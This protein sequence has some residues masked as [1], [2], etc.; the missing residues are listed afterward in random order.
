M[1]G[2]G[3]TGSAALTDST[4]LA[5]ST[6]PADSAAL[7][8]SAARADRTARATE[9]AAPSMYAMM[10]DTRSDLIDAVAQ[11]DRMIAQLTGMR[12]EAI[13]QARQWS[14]VAEDGV[15]PE[16]ARRSL[17]AEIACALRMPER[18][19][20]AMIEDSRALATDF[21]ATLEALRAG[22]IGYRHAQ[23]I[24]D[25]G[26]RL[27]PETRDA[28]E[29]AALPI[30]ATTTPSALDRRVRALRDRLDPSAM[31]ERHRRAAAD[32]SVDCAGARDGI[33]WLTAYLPV[34]QAVAIYSRITETA[35]ALQT[36]GE[37]RTL[38]QLRADVL[39]A[40][41]LD[42]DAESQDAKSQGAENRGFENQDVENQDADNQGDSDDAA[43]RPGSTAE[44][45]R[46][47]RPRV[48]VTVPVLTLLGAGDEP[49]VIEGYGPIDEDTARL[50]TAEAPSMTRLLTHPESRAVLSVGRTKYR[51]P[52]DLRSWLRVRDG[53][54]RFPHC[55]RSASNCD[56]DHTTDWQHGGRTD[57]R[58]LA[59]LCPKHH[60]LKHHGGW[61]VTQHDDTGALTWLSPAGRRYRTSPELRLG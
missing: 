38:T 47:I 16:F 1:E 59:Q 45:F 28:L 32:R 9:N 35:R 21:P 42:G 56:L 18:T 44:L 58:N 54:C 53:T 36:D 34:A 11:F 26:R 4:A 2:L 20:D 31:T 5:D 3:I 8:D 33:A 25:H 10:A 60:R 29:R 39:S 46:R 19:A 17:V 51:V 27:E 48:M 7:P 6:T 13:D 37:T 43:R 40:A 61:K 23:V 12:A 22:G 49:A 30:A 52:A 50:L 24:L 15:D 55:G 57:W 14:E 41:L